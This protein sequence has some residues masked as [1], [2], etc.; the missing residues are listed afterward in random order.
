MVEP[1]GN[2]EGL[3]NDGGLGNSE[4]PCGNSGGLGI[5]GSNATFKTAWPQS[6]TKE[7]IDRPFPHLSHKPHLTGAPSLCLGPQPQALK[8]S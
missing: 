7:V 5:G 2:G 6:W 3:G 4:G 8:V 1:L